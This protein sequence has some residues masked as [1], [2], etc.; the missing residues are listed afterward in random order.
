MS[1]LLS[2]HIPHS[3][4]FSTPKPFYMVKVLNQTTEEI[5]DFLKRGLGQT[6]KSWAGERHFSVADTRV[7]FYLFNREGELCLV[8]LFGHSDRANSP[9]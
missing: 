4:L 8:V 7:M 9:I 3:S 1:F 5:L 6:N 2:K